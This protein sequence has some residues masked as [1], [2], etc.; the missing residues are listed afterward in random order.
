[1]HPMDPPYRSVTSSQTREAG[2]AIWEIS[3]GTNTTHNVTMPCSYYVLRTSLFVV[4]AVLLA[5]VDVTEPSLE[6][7]PP[8]SSTKT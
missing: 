3:R 7:G 5:D 1:M 8:L 6:L 2:S 4:S